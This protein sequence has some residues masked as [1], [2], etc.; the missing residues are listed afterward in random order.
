MYSCPNRLFVARKPMFVGSNTFLSQIKRR[1]GV[2]KAGFSGTLDPFACGVLII[3]FGQYTKLF[4]FLKKRP[5]SYRATLWLGAVSDTLDIE[6]VERIEKTTPLDEEKVH[7]TLLS[8][9]G[10]FTYTPPKYSAKKV[11]GRRAYDLAR[12]GETVELPTLS[13][14]IYDIRLLHY[15]HPFITFEADVGEGTY[16]RSLAEAVAVKLGC[17]GALSYLERLR[18]GIFVFR[19]EEPLNPL[20]CLEP[21]KNRYLANSE[22]LMLGRKLRKESFENPE[23]GIYTVVFD[24]YF[25]IIEIEKSGNVLYLLNKVEL[26]SY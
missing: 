24:Q 11:G 8:F 15:R 12:R 3:A 23:P 1:Y 4:R 13:S 9:K 2:K 25:A 5:K 10:L 19:H 26:C 17:R 7:E 18:E 22:D 16:I 21:P 20:D 6:Q 14:E